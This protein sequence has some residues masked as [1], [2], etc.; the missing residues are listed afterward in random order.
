M[1]CKCKCISTTTPLCQI[2]ARNYCQSSTSRSIDSERLA[3]Q[4]QHQQC[5]KC[6]LVSTLGLF[7]PQAIQNKKLLKR[8]DDTVFLL[9]TP[10]NIFSII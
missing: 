2:L 5:G 3:K 1:P 9:P 6:L 4:A 7:R 10:F 8:Y